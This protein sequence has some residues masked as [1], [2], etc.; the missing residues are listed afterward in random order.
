M[1][2]FYLGVNYYRCDHWFLVA[3]SRHSMTSLLSILIIKVLSLIKY[4]PGFK[5]FVLSENA[6]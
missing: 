4:K 1:E 6:F 3:R 5:D 2:H